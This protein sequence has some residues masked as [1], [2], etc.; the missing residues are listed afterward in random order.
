MNHNDTESSRIGSN[1]PG[2][3]ALVFSLL[4]LQAATCVLHAAEL[5]PPRET[6]ATIALAKPTKSQLELQEMAFGLFVHW[7]PCVYQ[8]TDNDTGKTP[9]DA[10]VPDK[11]DADQI[12][13]AARSCGAGY[14]IFVAKHVG[15]YCTWQTKT[16]DYSIK[17]SPWKD[18][19]GDMVG[20]LANACAKAGLKFGVYLCPRDD[21][22]QIANG[23]KA[24]P[25]QAGA[26]AYYREQLTELLTNY[27]PMFEVW[28][29]G[30]LA[31]PVNDLFEK[32]APDAVTFLGRR[33]SS[34]RW[35]G[36]EY[37][38]TDYPCW[39]TVNGKETDLPPKGAGIPDGNR[40][41]PAECDVSILCPKW[42]WSPGCDARVL[43]LD[44]LMHIY[45]QSVGRSAVLLLSI[46]PDDHGAVPEVQMKRLA[47]LGEEIR[48]RF[49]KPLKTTSAVMAEATGELLLPLGGEVML[50]HVRLREDIRGGERVRRFTVEAKTGDNT[51]T[52][53]DT[54]SHIGVRQIIPFP[55]I[56][57]T[58]LRLKIN[59]SAGPPAIAEFAAF[60]AGRPVPKTAFRPTAMK[61]SAAVP[62]PPPASLATPAVTPEAQLYHKLFQLM[63][64]TRPGL[65]V[66][67]KKI[68]AGDLSAA[69]LEYRTALAARVSKFPR[70]GRFGY[71]LWQPANAD[72]M[73]EGKAT[74]IRYGD[75]NTR[76]TVNIG[77]PGQINFFAA[78]PE[79]RDVG[80]DISNLAW[81]N[82][83]AEAYGKTRDPKY[84]AGWCA[85]WVDFA[86]H[87]PE[88]WS[89][90]QKTNP[91]RIPSLGWIKGPLMIGM[92]LYAMHAGFVSVLQTAGDAGH[93]DQLDPHALA[94]IITRM[95]A[96]M[97]P[98]LPWL[99][100]AGGNQVRS[101]AAAVLEWGI[102]LPEMKDAQRWR[103]EA[104]PANISTCLPDGSDKEQSLNYF[105]NGIGPLLN[106]VRKRIPP[107][108]QTPALM[109]NLEMLNAYRGRV[110]PSLVRPDGFI[111]G[112][113]TDPV[114][115]KYGKT[116]KLSPPSTAFTSIVLPF[117][118]YAVQRDGW[119]PDS[120]FLFM[121]QT[122]PSWGHWRAIDGALQL[123]AYGRNLLVSPM[124]QIY[125]KRDSAGGWTTYWGS[126][127]SQNAIVVDGMSS[128][129][130]SGDFTKLNDWRWHSSACFDFMETDVTGPYTGIDFRTDG[131]SLG[132]RK[133]RKEWQPKP[134]VTD[135]VHRRQVH[136]IRDAG[137]WVVTDRLCSALPH[138]FTQSWCVGPEFAENEVAID[139]VAKIIR[140]RQAAGPN[141]SLYQFGIP[142]SKYEHYF[143]V[144]DDNHILG[145][146]GIMTDREKWMY[147]PAVAVHA[148]WRAQGD[149]VLVT[150]MAPR[151]GAAERVSAVVDKS[152]AGVSGF[153]AVLPDGRPVAYR[154]ATD[155]AFLEALGVKIDAGSLLVVRNPD[156]HLAGVVLDARTFD[157]KAVARPDLE[158]E[159]AGPG[160]S[161][162]TTPITAPNGFCWSGAGKNLIPGYT[163]P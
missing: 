125:D 126:A 107:E 58:G 101:L 11:F 97:G 12:V 76:H 45:Y 56:K 41:V 102:L 145:W 63:D 36:N 87:W 50:D 112:T 134:P 140:T 78:L 8:G 77:K 83:Y 24:G 123:S 42:F 136:F 95:S 111:F 103:D 114:W 33:Q 28:F 72:E 132:E 52:M 146:V 110:I 75:F 57:A 6:A 69:M 163:A 149:R 147:T 118:G 71:S 162:Q 1:L 61:L 122:R 144:R 157:G 40:W 20:E 89:E 5:P 43:R 139:S 137:C 49:G 142:D 93:L 99:K 119:K 30:G 70:N 66:V 152:G 26:N 39:S 35:G 19:K 85:T 135:V 7:S 16:S 124:G 67:R 15:G 96:D 51:W 3:R 17:K 100:R 128:A 156:G 133:Q 2:L 91:D 108:D 25:R 143:G 127:V 31:A 10:I 32:H 55:A 116:A 68:E 79:Y 98:A 9:V 27:G 115:D 90:R 160:Q 148:N 117:G 4:A 158:F 60:H 48:M 65:E 82:K 14:V 130:K 21:H 120:L 106:L 54:G 138:D 53:L 88:Q 104:I 153:D 80:R 129:E 81:I 161:P 74:T 38:T 131:L 159:M 94:G 141:L 151:P 84:L 64:L 154:A 113:G 105:N 155:H 29:D 92:R 109:A 23:G 59:Q 22:A 47:E 121:K 37:G 86:E 46:T 18:G 13:R 150:L 73:L 44:R 62:T 34:T